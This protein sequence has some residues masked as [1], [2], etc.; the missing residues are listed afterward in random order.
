MVTIQ[1]KVN[2]RLLAKADRLFTGSLSGRI[3]EILQN[4]RRAGATK[5]E[6][7]NKDN[8]VTVKDNGQGIMDFT[9]L[10]DL[11]G[12]GW[13]ES[14]EKSEDPAGVGIFC[15]APRAVTIR[16]K[17]KIVTIT[18]DGWLSTPMELISDPEPVRRGTILRFSDESW[19]MES[20]SIHAA[21]SGMRVIVDGKKCPNIPFVSEKAIHVPTLGCRVEVVESAQLSQWHHASRRREG[22]YGNMGTLNFHGQVVTFFCHPISENDL[23]YM[24]DLT[25]EPTGIRLMLPA[26]TQL[27]ENEAYKALL[28]AIEL[29]AYRHVQK[30]GEHKL[31]YKEYSR[32]KELGITLPEA[33]PAF[34]VGLLS[35]PDSPEPV[36][37]TMPKDF[38][39]EK[40]Y[41]FDSNTDG[42]EADE[43][44]A[45]LLAALGKT[46]EPFAPVRINSNYDGYT[47][48]RLPTIGKVD[49][50][51]GKELHSDWLWSGKL[52]CVE[53]LS[54][55][56]HTSDGKVFSSPVCMA[57]AQQIPEE[58]PNWMD[59]HMLV[60]VQSQT[61]LNPSQI[62]FHLGGWYEDGDTYDTQEIAFEKDLNTFWADLAG[63]D[64]YLRQTIVAPLD[65][66]MS[67]WKAAHVYPDGR[68]WIENT[69]GT[70]KTIQ[71]P[72]AAA[73][74]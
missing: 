72:V 47:W 42:D 19:D 69:D 22:W 44:N 14:C 37:V 39:L 63:P 31:P 49:V 64:E 73:A 27:V 2:Q 10:L 33:T 23:H 65:R 54:I 15:L 3:I 28:D 13:D 71:P 60:T 74:S 34:D 46:E 5:V 43:T 41:R 16:S 29:A 17:R 18:E 7:T 38:P 9:K 4:A 32:A 70:E 30:R 62:W 40:C 26:R 36:E 52:T 45:H 51:S 68:V 21:F 20:V 57:K 8:F 67:Q 25:G 48:T 56:V 12:S 24:V 59:N 1:A 53:R 35:N 50:H 66:I 11:G 58:K 6:I 61:R 55:T